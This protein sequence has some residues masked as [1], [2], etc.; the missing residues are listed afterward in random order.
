MSLYDYSLYM[1][2]PKSDGSLRDRLQHAGL[3]SS[4]AH[5]DEIRLLNQARAMVSQLTIAAGQNA[6]LEVLALLVV[7]DDASL[8]TSSFSAF[9]DW[10]F[11]AARAAELSTLFIPGGSD[12]N[13]FWQADPKA[14]EDFLTPLVNEG[15]LTVAHALMY[16][17]NRL[18]NRLCETHHT[19]YR[20]ASDPRSGCLYALVDVD[21]SG[22]FDILEPGPDHSTLL[23]PW[24]R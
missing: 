5:S 17:S 2:R 13:N 11:S 24:K 14:L 20:R 21:E 22:A 7:D 15:N 8:L 16:F 1:V 4:H 10:I 9:K 19:S 3:I 6:E 12:V 18:E 23:S